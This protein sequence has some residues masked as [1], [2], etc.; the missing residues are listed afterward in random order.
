MKLSK[1]SKI[2]TIVTITI[3]VS[4]FHLTVSQGQMSA[5]M[6]HREL[7]LIPIV[8]SC[9]WF[10]LKS[11]LITTGIICLI[12]ISKAFLGAHSEMLFAPT[13]FQVF[14]FLLIS[15]ILGTLVNNNEKVHEENIRK[16]ELAALGN[17][18]LN[19]GNDVQDVLETLKRSFYKMN[20]DLSGNDEIEE[21]FIRLSN[22][23]KILTSFVSTQNISDINFD[24]NSLI[25]NQ[26]QKLTEKITQAGVEVKTQLDEHACLSKVSKESVNKLIKDLI[27]NAIEASSRGGKIYVRT[28]HRPTYNIL[29]V[30]DEGSGIKKEHLKKMFRPFFTTKDGS[31]GLSLASNYKFIKGSG[32]LME[33]SSVF[34]KG[35]LF[36]VKIPIEDK[37]KPI[38]T[39]TQVSD[40]NSERD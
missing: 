7:F 17:A 34:G 20:I 22:L 9:F 4:L 27:I 8:L 10:G 39:M 37:S 18:A 2:F 13:V 40:W 5:H 6:I 25:E 38:N 16:K 33:V 31:H 23:V 14:S 11:G 15:V 26:L 3:A 24:I 21:G 1:E 12:Y 28:S 29:E 19:L 35:A 36:K 32:G 30:E